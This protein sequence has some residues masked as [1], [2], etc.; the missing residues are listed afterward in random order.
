MSNLANKVKYIQI[1]S[2]P[3]H[4]VSQ[5][6]LK[7]LTV[8]WSRTS[9]NLIFLQKNTNTKNALNFSDLRLRFRFLQIWLTLGT[10]QLT[11]KP[12]FSEI[13]FSLKKICQSVVTEDGKIGLNYVK[14]ISPLLLLP[15]LTVEHSSWNR[16]YPPTP[17][18][19]SSKNNSLDS[20]A[21]ALRLD[22]FC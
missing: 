16:V 6:I 18:L 20:T 7:S 19:K 4:F 8:S 3:E 12:H 9:K 2:I 21:I 15:F 10:Y 5:I 14:K 1:T 11:H 17:S 22:T 13:F